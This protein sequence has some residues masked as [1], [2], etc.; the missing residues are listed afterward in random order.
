MLNIDLEYYS[1]VKLFLSRIAVD[2]SAVSCMVFYCSVTPST[3]SP[4]KV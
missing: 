2:A 1:H 4:F 3:F